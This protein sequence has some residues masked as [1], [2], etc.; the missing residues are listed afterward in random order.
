MPDFYSYARS[1][2]FSLARSK[3]WSALADGTWNLIHLPRFAFVTDVFLDIITAYTAAGSTLTVGYVGN[4]EA[5][6]NPDGFLTTDLAKP[7]ETGI[8]RAQKV[9]LGQ[10]PGYWFNSGSG[11]LTITSD[12]NG[13]TAGTF[14]VFVVYSILH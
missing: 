12:D 7:L 6:A 5:V 4:Q 11:I 14:I 9:A 2:N 3:T 8:K 10:Y 1:D 13:G